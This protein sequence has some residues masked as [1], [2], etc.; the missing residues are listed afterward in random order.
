MEEYRLK[1][2]FL[3][4]FAKFVEW[5]RSSE[6]DFVICVVGDSS[7]ADQ[8]RDVVTGKSVGALP[9]SVRQLETAGQTDDCRILF[10]AASRELSAEEVSRA[11]AGSSVLT[12]GET[13]EFTER[14][15]MIGF[16]EEGSRLRF[17]I[18]KKVAEAAGLQISSRLLKLARAVRE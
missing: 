17:Q 6:S 11:T 8:V 10:V 13:S 4:N 14:G 9:V 12:V 2:A 1:G 7:V 5:P 3:Y 16:S 18:N 15:G